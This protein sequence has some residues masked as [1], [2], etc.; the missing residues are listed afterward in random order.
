MYDADVFI[1]DGCY[2]ANPLLPNDVSGPV[3]A[4]VR[5]SRAVNRD[6]PTGYSSSSHN[7]EQDH[8]EKTR[9]LS[10]LLSAS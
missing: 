9:V 8:R 6:Y 4:I 1:R 10:T 2:V 3:W 7:K 5:G